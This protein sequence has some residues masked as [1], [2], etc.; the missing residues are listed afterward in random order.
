MAV[1]DEKRFEVI[2]PDS[3]TDS[4]FEEY[5]FMLGWFNEFGVPSQWLFYDWENIYRVRTNPV[6]ETDPDK[7]QSL[8]ETEDNILNLTAEDIDRSEISIF[9]SLLKSKIVYR[10]FTKS[11]E[12][13]YERLAMVDNSIEWLQ[14]KQRFKIE[15]SLKK[16]SGKLWT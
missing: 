3:Y 5:E 12:M 9:K 16:T 14:S 4:V 2:T 15:V 6:N 1:L 10:I 7:I 8:P 11:S 13:G